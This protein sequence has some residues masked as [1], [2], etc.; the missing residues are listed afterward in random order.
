MADGVRVRVRLGPVRASA[1]QRSGEAMERRGRDGESRR[2]FTSSAMEVTTLDSFKETEFPVWDKIGAVVR[3]SY[4][5]GEC[6]FLSP[7]LNFEFYGNKKLLLHLI[8]LLL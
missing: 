1:E 8:F 6:F 3:L 4:G 7:R 2:G 5:I